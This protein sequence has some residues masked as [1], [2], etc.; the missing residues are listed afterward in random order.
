MPFVWC[1][2]V[3]DH[4]VACMVDLCI[5]SFVLDR[6]PFWPGVRLAV[7]LMLVMPQF[8]GA[9]LVRPFIHGFGIL[10]EERLCKRKAF[11]DV[12]D[13]YVEENGSE[14]LEKLIVSQVSICFYPFCI[15]E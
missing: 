4:S 15:N 13:K 11:L 6:T 3:D 7:S 8:E 2:C 12:V 10:N 1:I 5:I 14:A 9:G